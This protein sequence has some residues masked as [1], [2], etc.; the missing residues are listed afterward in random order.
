MDPSLTPSQDDEMTD[1]ICRKA[2]KHIA[3]RLT[4]PNAPR[5]PELGEAPAGE[6][7]GGVFVP[8]HLQDLKEGDLPENQRV[9]VLDQIAVFREASARRDREKKAQEDER[10]RERYKA[11]Q[12]MDSNTVDYGYGNSRGLNNQ[13]KKERAWGVPQNQN[14]NQPPHQQA[15]G[16]GKERERDPQGYDAPVNFVKAQAAESKEQSD[17]TDEEEEM[18]RQQRRDRDKSNAL[19][20]VSTRAPRTSA[21]LTWQKEFKVEGRE[22]QRIDAMNRELTARKSH[23]DWEERHRAKMSTEL[24]HWD[25]DEKLDRG[26]ELFFTDRSVPKIRGKL[27]KLSTDIT[28][29]AGGHNV[30]KSANVNTKTTYEIVNMKKTRSR[31]WRQNQRHS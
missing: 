16:S 21:R 10:E 30:A 24:E 18:L 19:K 11:G 8:A 13:I 14:Q 5:P 20:E 9:A 1:S 6:E 26:R 31:L 3:A 29:V 15:N 27:L 23:A 2:V 4:D 12:K 28:D 25:D 22:R 7:Q 17:R